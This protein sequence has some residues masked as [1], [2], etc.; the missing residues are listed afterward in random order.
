MV[1]MLF[2]HYSFVYPIARDYGKLHVVLV[3]IKHLNVFH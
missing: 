2:A 1:E 3:R